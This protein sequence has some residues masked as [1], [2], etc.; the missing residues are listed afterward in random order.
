[1]RILSLSVL[2]QWGKKHFY[3]TNGVA[4]MDTVRSLVRAT[5]ALPFN[6]Y[7]KRFHLNLMSLNEHL[8]DEAHYLYIVY[9]DSDFFMLG[10]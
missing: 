9:T 10:R 7:C 4:E 5:K 1:M 8:L 2:P 6:P 3:L